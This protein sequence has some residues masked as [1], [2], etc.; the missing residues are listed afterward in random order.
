MG[1]A[2]ARNKGAGFERWA[3]NQLKKHYPY[4][5]R[6]LEY[7]A[8][9]ARGFDLRGTGPLRIQC[10]AFKQYAPISKIEEV[11][12]VEGTIPALLTKGDRKPPVICLYFSDFLKI[13]DDIGVLYDRSENEQI[14]EKEN[15]NRDH[16]GE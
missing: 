15:S 16:T 1:G 13:L 10:K 6:H 4:C 14:C 3:A 7:Q 2:H 5:E 9:Q 8:S 11:R 12:D